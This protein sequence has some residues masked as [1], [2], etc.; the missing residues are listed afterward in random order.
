M[1]KTYTLEKI[2]KDPSNPGGYSSQRKLLKE[3]RLVRKDINLKDV[4]NY[5]NDQIS[6]T[7]HGNVPRKYIKRRV[8]I[9]EGPGFLISADLADMGPDL[10]KS[11]DNVRFLMF[12][13]DCFSRKL[14]VFLYLISRELL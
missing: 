2:Y 3:A 8:K 10:K 1:S 12:V 6:Y 4:K 9:N 14:W 11:N 5:L 7:R 13:I